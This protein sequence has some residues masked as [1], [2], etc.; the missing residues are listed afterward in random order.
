MSR[1]PLGILCLA[2]A[3]PRL[4]G[5]LDLTP[6]ENWRELEGTRIPTLIFN[7]PAGK[8]R[9]QPPGDW[10]INGDTNTLS[11]YPP[12]QEAF[13]QFRVFPRK[14]EQADLA[15]AAEDL[16]KWSKTFLSADAADVALLEERLSPFTLSGRASREFI[17]DYKAGGQ[18][19]H[20]GVAICDLDE[21]Q[22]FVVVITAR[23]ADFSAVH[24]T[25]IA[26][27]FSWSRRKQDPPAKSP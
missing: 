25:G 6:I 16:V 2:A 9:Y 14:P 18:R 3:L 23:S 21:R 26:S 22:R 15:G 11:L 17:Y 1:L 8:V 13:M 12:Q 7:D 19:F 20:T 4:A 24:D 10:R 27:L 5:A